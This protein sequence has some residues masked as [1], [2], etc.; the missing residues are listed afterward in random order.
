MPIYEYICQKCNKEIEI[1]QHFD[2]SPP[3]CEEC[4]DEMEKV[5]SL[6]SFVLKG[7]CWYKDGYTKRKTN[8]IDK[9]S[10]DKRTTKPSGK[11]QDK[12]KKT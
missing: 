1:I 8:E 3:E 10:S 5:M 11:I 2:D 7:D 9:L 12:C 4:G 6:S